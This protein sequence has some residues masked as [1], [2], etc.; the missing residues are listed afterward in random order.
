[1]AKYKNVTEANK[2]S[3]MDKLFY[4]LGRGM[5][6]MMVRKMSAKDP[7]FAAKWKRLEKARDA[8]DKHFNL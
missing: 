1:M 5:R 3:L 6:P 4:Y 7:K 8:V 2:R